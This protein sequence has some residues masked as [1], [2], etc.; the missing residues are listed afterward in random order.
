MIA[1][2][3]RKELREAL[4]DGRVR[5]LGVATLLLLVGALALGLTAARELRAERE[6]AAELTRRHW[7]EQPAKNPHSAAHYGI[8]A[9]KPKPLLAMLDE[10]VDPYVGVATWLEAHKQNEFQ[11]RPAADATVAQ[12]FGSLTAATILQLLL[13]LVIVLL[14]FGTFAGEREQGTLRLA[15]GSGIPARVLA[16]GKALGMAAVVALLVGPAAILAVVALALST[17]AEA[18]RTVPRLGLLLAI[19]LL[20]YTAWTGV[21]IAVSAWSSS[22]RVALVVLLGLWMGSGLLA[23]RAVTDLVRRLHPTPSAFEFQSALARE[24][25]LGPDGRST[26]AARRKAL[27]ARVLRQYGV[28]SVTQLPV[29]FAGLALDEGE[30]HGNAVFDRHYGALWAQFSRQ[31]RTRE[32]AGVVAP[33]LAVRALSMALAGT[34]V[35]QHERFTQAAERYR[36]ELVTAMNRDMIR[37][38]G[39]EDF[40]YRAPTALW[41]T[42]PAFTYEMPGIG[43]VL[44]RHAMALVVLLGWAAGGVA[45][46]ALAVRTIRP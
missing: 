6:R 20:F 18:L 40:E 35:S 8:Y 16:R 25:E 41:S 46:A 13:P 4:R 12:R 22:P 26:P 42:V 3:V 37:N 45:L 7:L 36:R 29:N 34:D 11:F 33:V 2:I 39:R 9:F 14:G 44:E 5:A 43:W 21:A 17:P 19:Y 15:L 27:E 31:E 24:L 28:D 30:A 38:A 32:A 23:P 1:A 10:G